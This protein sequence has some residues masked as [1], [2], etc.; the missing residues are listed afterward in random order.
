MRHV[1]FDFD[2]TIADSEHVALNIMNV[3]ADRHGYRRLSAD[4][5]AALKKMPI[6]D[7]FRQLGLPMRKLPGWAREY[8]LLFHDEV[9]KVDPFDG[10]PEMLR[11]LHQKGYAISILSSNVEESIRRFLKRHQLDFVKDVWCSHRIFSKDKMIRRLMRREGLRAEDVVYVGDEHRDI[12][13]CKRAG[14]RVIW[15]QWGFDGVEAVAS[16]NPDYMAEEPVDILGFVG[17]D[18]EVVPAQ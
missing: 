14:V 7:R 6:R 13:A 12:V 2:G 5:I 18:L 9:L 3:L 8:N 10:I 17:A 15:V 11:A 1:L 4:E 16:E